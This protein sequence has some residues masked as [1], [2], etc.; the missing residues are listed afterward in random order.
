[1][2]NLS[3]LPVQIVSMASFSELI[4]RYI[5]KFFLAVLDGNSEEQM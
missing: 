2:V 3:E 5:R 1:V 4:I